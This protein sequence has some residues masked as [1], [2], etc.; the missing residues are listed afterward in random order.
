MASKQAPQ[1]AHWRAPVAECIAESLRTLPAGGSFAVRV[2]YTADQPV[3]SLTPRRRLSHFHAENTLSRRVLAFV[4]QGG[5]LV[6][7][8]E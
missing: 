6:A 4:S 7:G 2:V 5:C 3:V 1:P 8:L